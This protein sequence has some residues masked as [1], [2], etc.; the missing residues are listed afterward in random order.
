MR[1]AL[2]PALFFSFSA[3][4][5]SIIVLVK[6]LSAEDKFRQMTETPIRRL[7]TTLAV[8]TVI[9]NLISTLYNAADTF[10]VGQI[11]TSASAAVGVALSLQAVIQAIGFFFGQ[12][13]GNN[14]SRQLGAHHEKT[15]EQLASTG[16][17]S[18]F[19]LSILIMVVGIIFLEPLSIFLGSSETILPYA[20]DY[21]FWILIASPFMASSFVLNNQLRFEGNSFYSMIGLTTGGILNLVLDPLLIFGFGMGIA[22]AAIATAISQMVSFTILFILS[23]RIGTVRIRFRSFRPTRKML[24]MIAN[25]GL[26]SLCRQ[27]VTSVAMISLNNA[28]LPYGDAAIAA[29]AIVNKIGNFTNSILIGIGQGFQPVCGYN[30]GAGCYKRVREAFWF[31]LKSMTALLAVLAVVEFIWA[32]PIVGFFRK[33]DPEVIEIG[34]I[35]LR[36]RCFTLIFSSW[37]TMSNMLLQT[38]GKMWRASILGFARQGLIL[39]PIVW[40]LPPFIGIWGIQ[41]AQPLADL[42]TFIMAVPMTLGVIRKMNEDVRKDIS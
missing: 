14:I 28:A 39:I 37:I 13:S 16:F 41:I 4:F 19:F 25:G 11:S 8:P 32:T 40:L 24:G 35:A 27:S 6:K 9:S 18:S 2:Q 31:C 42:I 33:G 20:M 15:A 30:Y 38:T 29:M 21:M 5:G 10:F 1:S 34:D 7:V 26:P 3:S 17:F 12:G 23:E 36:L 22:G